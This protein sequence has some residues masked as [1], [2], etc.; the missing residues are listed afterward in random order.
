MLKLTIK[1]NKK[2][3]DYYHKI[4]RINIEYCV[5][6]D[7]GTVIIGYNPDWKQNCHLGKRNTQNF[8]TIPYYKLIQQLDYKATEQG[9]V[10]IKQEESHS[11]KCSFLDNEVIEHH[12][13]Y[14]GRRITNGLFKS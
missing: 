10:I 11:S 2:I 1:R 13:K 4:S 9:I 6:N 5:L 3:N 7:I 14:L 12:N 8:V